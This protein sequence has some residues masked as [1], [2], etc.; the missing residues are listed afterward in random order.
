M[1]DA[2]FKHRSSVLPGHGQHTCVWAVLPF[3]LVHYIPMSI[4][5]TIAR[6]PSLYI[7]YLLKTNA[8]GM[9]LRMIQC[10]VQSLKA[11]LI[12][13]PSY[14]EV[15]AGRHEA[16]SG[17]WCPPTVPA[18]LSLPHP[19]LLSGIYFPSPPLWGNSIWNFTSPLP[20][21]LVSSSHDGWAPHS[22]V[23]QPVHHAL[24]LGI[25]NCK[26]FTIANPIFL[27][28]PPPHV[29]PQPRLQPNHTCHTITITK[30]LTAT[31][32]ATSPCSLTH[33]P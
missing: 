8:A 31:I 26:R 9:I 21:S 10:L 25:K 14:P 22:G 23:S 11:E 28:L 20:L 19:S 17:L 27:Q 30:S 18:A 29:S 16:I 15:P 1:F 5:F 12:S 3:P 33:Y 13:R 2:Q 4:H 6:S 7:D 32:S 24:R